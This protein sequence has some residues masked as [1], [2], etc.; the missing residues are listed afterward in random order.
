VSVEVAR[1]IPAEVE[2]LL[3]DPQTSGGLLISIAEKDAALLERKL[4]GS[5][6]IGRVLAKDAK[7][8]RLL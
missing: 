4:P 7:A 5:Y 2:N 1:E 6:R 3:Y 8:I